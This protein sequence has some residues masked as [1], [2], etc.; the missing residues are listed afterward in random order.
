[1]KI[2]IYENLENGAG[3]RLEDKIWKTLQQVETLRVHSTSALLYEI[4]RP[5]CGISIVIFF[6]SGVE[7]IL[8]LIDFE[9]LFEDLKK[10]V[11]LPDNEEESVSLAMQLQPS[12]VYHAESDCDRILVVLSKMIS[13]IQ[14]YQFTW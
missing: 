13:T 9:P 8:E 2:L 3:Y 12:F 7:N 6:P 4:C 1:M 11:I 14:S 10:I 5:M